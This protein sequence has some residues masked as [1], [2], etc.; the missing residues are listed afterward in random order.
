MIKA[1]IFILKTTTIF[2]VVVRDCYAVQG[3]P[4]S[5]SC[6]V[7]S[8]YIN[9][10]CECYNGVGEHLRCNDE[11]HIVGLKGCSC[12][13]YNLSS[14][15]TT[16]GYCLYGC[17]P[18]HGI[19]FETPINISSIN[20]TMCGSYKRNGTLCG[21]CHEG[22]YPAV[23]SFS[24][25]C[26]NCKHLTFSWITFLVWSLVP[27]TIFY[28]VIM[29]LSE[30]LMS[31]KLSGYIIFSQSIASPFIVRLL[32][33]KNSRFRTFYEILGAI[34]GIWNLDFLRTFSNGICLGTNSLVTLFLDIV[35]AIYPFI[36]IIFTHKCI[37]M[38]GENKIVTAM[39]KPI[40]KC[41]T[42]FKSR[43]VK[44]SIIDSIATF[45]YLINIK[46]LN[47]CFDL[48]VPV[49]IYMLTDREIKNT[50]TRLFYD[51]DIVYFGAAHK[52]YGITAAIVVI[53]FVLF[54]TLLLLVYPFKI[55]QKLLNLLLSSRCQL[56]VR[57]FVESFNRCYKDGTKENEKD[58]RYFAAFPFIIRITMFLFYLMSPNRGVFVFVAVALTMY[59]LFLVISE[60]FKGQYKHLLDSYVL[61][62]ILLACCG[63]SYDMYS[64]SYPGYYHTQFYV[65]V[66]VFIS[67]TSPG[68][69]IVIHFLYY[70]V[71]LHKQHVMQVQT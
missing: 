12:S 5:K 48:L 4:N 7:W 44:T 13:T 15:V 42:K 3:N 49:N 10:A 54:P 30:N 22:T 29:L 58:Y 40:V 2:A 21:T 47:S 17:S 66:F 27:V 45:V 34:Y 9:D 32:L 57:T 11:G 65:S 59:S 20:S 69:Y 8:S 6:P 1:A 24:M 51:A 33:L 39:L 50:S 61:F 62:N 26:I 19:S 70:T 71:A 38:Y 67:L 41:T 68:V 35:I 36:L 14:S 28:M 25:T 52:P 60:P 63:V 23:Y 43:K 16:I 31:S 46:I 64:N 18:F 56:F 37:N 55:L 53:F